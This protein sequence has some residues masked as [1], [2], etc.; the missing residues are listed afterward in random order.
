ML[1]Y[2][3]IVDLE[4]EEQAFGIEAMRKF[5][6][7]FCDSYALKK[8]I[9]MKNLL[10]T[11]EYT[12]IRAEAHVL[13]AAFLSFGFEKLNDTAK[14][15]E[16]TVDNKNYSKLEQLVKDIKLDYEMTIIEFK[17]QRPTYFN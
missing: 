3:N 5:F 15:I 7:D 9:D 16:Q 2:V 14:K 12:K 4:K 1:S 6:E 13:R 10:V 17:K 8:I 11:K